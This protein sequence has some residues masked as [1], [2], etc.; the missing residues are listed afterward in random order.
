MLAS[1]PLIPTYATMR[2]K[3]KRKMGLCKDGAAAC[4]GPKRVEAEPYH[5][6]LFGP[7]VPL[8]MPKRRDDP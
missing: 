3:E 8:E 4:V 5:V 6:G 7:N 1:H 2:D